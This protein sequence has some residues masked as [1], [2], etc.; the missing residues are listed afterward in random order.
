VKNKALSSILILL[1]F[2]VFLSTP[3]MGSDLSPSDDRYM[4]NVTRITFEGDNGEAYFSRDGR[5]LIYQSNRGGEA[6]DKIW[7]M[8]MDGIGLE[9]VADN[10]VFDSFPMFSLTGKNWPG[11]PTAILKNHGRRI[12]I[13]VIG[14]NRAD[15]PQSS[16]W[17]KADAVLMLVEFNLLLN[18]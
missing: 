10:A 2:F 17:S 14:P 11:P 7:I 9:R 16:Q 8:N 5:R 3:L 13:S 4:R 12:S 18:G 6:C 15:T 1:L